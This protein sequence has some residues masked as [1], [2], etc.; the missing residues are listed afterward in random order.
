MPITSIIFGVLLIIIGAVG[1]VH[2]VMNDKGSITALIPAFFGIVIA[3]LGL[4]A[5]TKE[6]LRMHLMH[7]AVLVGLVGFLASAGR[8]ASKFSEIAMTPAYIAQIAMAV[9]CLLYVI[10]AVRSFIAARRA[11]TA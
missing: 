11:R 6:S 4:A 1:Y 8:L 5:Q 2:G 7:A 3:L 9:A 10:F